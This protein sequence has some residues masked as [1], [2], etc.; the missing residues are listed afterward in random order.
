MRQVLFLLWISCLLCQEMFSQPLVTRNNYS[1]NWEDPDSWVPVW[2]TPN[3]TIY[4]T[5]TY[6]NGFI[7]VNSSLCLTGAVCDLVITDT[8]VINGDLSLGNLS[9][10]YVNEN[11]ILIVKGNLIIINSTIISTSGY[12][13]IAGDFSNT[14][15]TW[16]GSFISNS[17]PSKV[18]ITGTV[19]SLNNFWYPA[20]NCTSPLTMPYPN[21]AC[22]YG[23]R[24]DL[25]NDPIY[26]F[27]QSTHVDAVAGSNSPVC[28]GSTI[29]LS[30]SGGTSYTWSGPNSF[31]S[32][33]QNPSVAGANLSMSGL[34]KVT[35]TDSNGFSDT[36]SLPVLVI[37]NPIA[38][39]G[40]NQVLKNVFETRMEAL[41]SEGE[42]GEW[43]MVTGQGLIGDPGS[44]TT[45][46]TGLAN[47]ENTLVWTVSNGNC[48]ASEMVT[49]TVEDAL[50]PS[51]I[52]PNG[53]NKNDFFIIKGETG[54]IELTVF[55]RWGMV[56]YSSDD[57]LNDWGGRS[58]K[59]V[60]LPDDT[61]FY[62][63]KYSNG[64]IRKGTVLIKSR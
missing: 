19:P 48:E 56:E 52:T 4:G 8:L 61:Y 38:N 15:A 29:N 34:Y 37:E 53:D 39:A 58:N 57:Y 60:E 50:I 3:D 14:S 45:I 36:T 5:D 55:N 46:V 13:V 16:G 64:E 33:Q 63:I 10:L 43:A 18:F 9:T 30:A 21:S 25:M 28:E 20:I 11:A 12:L 2:A 23:N 27:F 62:V 40:S 22:S 24:T 41:L 26:S 32:N 6:I 59:G 35:V 1:G 49:V 17:N 31:T 54:R 47:G 51:V 44:P 42:T 7:T